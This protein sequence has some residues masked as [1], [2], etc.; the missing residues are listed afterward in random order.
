MNPARF[1]FTLFFALVLGVL[2][3][4]SI[5]APKADLWEK[6]ATHNPSSTMIIQ[7]DRWTNWLGRFVTRHAD[8]IHR[9]AYGR[10][11][12]A[13]RQQ[14]QQYI[15]GL[16]AIPISDFNRSEQQAYWINL[17]NALTVEV[18]LGDYPVDSI[19]DIKSGI[20]SSGPWG[21]KLVEV[22]RE[23][24]SLD[25]I[26][27]RILRPI[28]KDPRI[29]YAVNCASIGCPNL[30]M[31]AF[32]AS[33]MEGLLNKA[34]REYVNHERGAQVIDGEL[35]V[36]SIYDWFVEDFGGN[37]AGVIKHL[38]QYAGP[39]LRNQLGSIDRI[40]DDAYDWKLNDTGTAQ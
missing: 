18:I 40:D 15:E 13:A 2:S 1:R 29:H 26:E 23:K 27:H 28:W 34:A 7:H 35:V 8:G 31:Q 14:L 5:A 9:V 6:W 32:T 37:D 33:N 3:N 11:D 22:E 38:K 16:A 19:R 30:L 39:R 4:P 25:D 24:L 17:Y 12:A 10:V 21:R 20:F 36:S